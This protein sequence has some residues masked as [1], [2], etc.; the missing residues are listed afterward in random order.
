MKRI[1]KAHRGSRTWG[2]RISGLVDGVKPIIRNSLQIKGFT[3][4]ELLVVIAIIAILAS[5]LLPALSRAREI[6]KSVV[7]ASQLKQIGL[8]NFN[9]AND[10]NGFILQCYVPALYNTFTEDWCWYQQAYPY[11]NNTNVYICPTGSDSIVTRTAPQNGVDTNGD[12]AKEDF[13]LNYGMNAAV[14][15]YDDGIYTIGSPYNRLT[16]FGDPARTVTFIDYHNDLQFLQ[17]NLHPDQGRQ[18]YV[19]RH[20]R[21]A[22]CWFLDGHVSGLSKPSSAEWAGWTAQYIWSRN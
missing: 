5:L 21:S 6:A 18:P 11:L 22:N 20:S 15:G 1:G 13:R 3:L 10:Y 14:G 19:F 12:G 7:C 9:R 8:A 2:N 17:Y 4:I 16:T